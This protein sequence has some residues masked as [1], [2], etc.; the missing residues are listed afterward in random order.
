MK[1]ILGALVAGYVL[2]A[3]L[4]VRRG[5]SLSAVVRMSLDG[6]RGALGLA[7]VLLVIGAVTGVW[8]ASGTIAACVRLGIEAITP[9]LFLAVTFLVC[10]AL[11]YALGTSFGV[12]GT[13]GVVFMTL[14]RGGV[15]PTI[16]AGVILSGIYFGDRG[17]P[18][19][20]TA[21][22]VAGLTGTDLM[23][24]VRRMMRTAAVPFV[25]TLAFYGALSAAHP[26]RLEDAAAAEA[27]VARFSLSAWAL[28]PAALMVVLPLLGVSVFRS[29]GASIAAAAGTAWAVQGF[30]PLEIARSCVLGYHSG[31][32]GMAALLDGGGM[33]SMVDVVAIVLLSCSYT[34]I[35]NGTNMLDS[36]HR[37]VER[38]SA[39][40]GRFGTMIVVCLCSSAVFCNQVIAIVTSEN[41]LGPVYARDGKSRE[42]LAADIENSAIL[43]PA[44]IPWCILSSV[45]LAILGSSYA[46]V[47]YAAYAYAVP[48]CTL[49]GHLRA[50]KIVSPRAGRR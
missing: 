43:L 34:G 39:R 21:H 5:H 47:P 33:I 20:S 15:N 45:P 32:E 29:M 42:D 50:E 12:A 16:T 30:S 4:A 6:A 23:S 27:L 11:S 38:L 46:A 8:R 14:A 28:L 9:Q 13:A 24:N 22:M 37:L 36:L 2:F 48:L 26:L 25:L 7:M 31:G 18:M 1:F 3:V 10:C 17:S 44:L 49:I 40:L 41:F 19:S 35:F